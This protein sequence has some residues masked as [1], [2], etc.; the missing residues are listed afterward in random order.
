MAVGAPVWGASDLPAPNE[1][2]PS[3]GTILAF[4]GRVSDFAES[5]LA[6]IPGEK[7]ADSLPSFL[8]NTALP[9]WLRKLSVIQT[10]LQPHLQLVHLISS[11]LLVQAIAIELR[12]QGIRTPEA[13]KVYLE[14]FPELPFETQRDFAK[15]VLLLLVQEAETSVSSVAADQT[16]IDTKALQALQG[17]LVS[18]VGQRENITRFLLIQMALRAHVYAQ[19]VEQQWALTELFEPMPAHIGAAALSRVAA[20]QDEPQRTP[21]ERALAE[22]G[23][24]EAKL[25]ILSA[26]ENMVGS[27]NVQRLVGAVESGCVHYGQ[28]LGPTAKGF[29]ERGLLSILQFCSVSPDSMYG[30]MGKWAASAVTGY[31][32]SA[33]TER[34]S[35]AFAAPMP[36]ASLA[37]EVGSRDSGAMSIPALQA[38]RQTLIEE[39]RQL[40][41]I[42]TP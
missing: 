28:L 10:R 32:S 14:G 35:S 9:D 42:E 17:F 22:L 23:V 15:R 27:G 33:V 1:P 16:G 25:R 18:A 29:L 39:I 4:V 24:I 8:Q 41:E 36:L 34:V 37:T 6:H 40:G 13:A 21:R 11:P 12:E 7:V 19:Q 2:E 26:A 5:L 3:C 38:R 31:F 30:K 20:W